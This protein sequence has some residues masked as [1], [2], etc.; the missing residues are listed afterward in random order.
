MGAGFFVT[1]LM[2]NDAISIAGMSTAAGVSLVSWPE[3]QTGND[4]QLWEFIPDPAGSGYFFIKTKLNGNVISIAGMSTAA[5]ASLLSW[6][7]KQTGNDDQLWQ[8]TLGSPTL[9]APAI[10]GITPA[11]AGPGDTIVINGQNFGAQQGTGYVLFSDNQVNWGQPGDVAT[12]ELQNWSDTQISF[13][14]PVKDS[15]GYQITPGT[16]ACITVTNSSNLTSNTDCLALHSDVKWPVALD[17]GATQ[18]GNTGNGFMDTSVT[19]DQAGNLTASTRVWDT[20]MWGF[21]TGFHGAVV[22]CLY[23]TFGNVIGTFPSG[24]YGVQG[25]QNNVNPWSATVSAAACAELY[26]VSIVNFYDPQYNVPGEIWNWIINNAPA[27]ANAATAV[28]A[29]F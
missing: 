14:V 4:D 15:Q 11:T 26:S 1:N 22:V 25:Q 6:P 23:D 5:G 19:I 27:I 7:Q 16:T 2:D 24:P 29:A 13:L 8:F 17:S 10:Y 28:V 9:P 3:K 12:F 18:I 20:S 21:L